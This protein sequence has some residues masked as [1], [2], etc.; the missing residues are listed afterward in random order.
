LEIVRLGLVQCSLGAIV[1]LCTSTF[2]RVMVVEL[3]LA[4]SVPAG[5]VAWH[6]A[7]QMSRPRWGFCAD[8]GARRTPWIIGGMGVLALGAVL[9]SD[10]IALM[11]RAP[12]VGALLAVVAF[13][14]I[15]IG[16]G[17]AGT[18]LLA[19][20]A[21]QTA[22]ERRPAAAAIT[23]I[24]MI[25]GIVVCTIIAG[26]QL[27][28]YSEQRLAMVTGGVALI[29]FLV[30]LAAVNGI[31][32]Q[33][34]TAPEDA[35]PSAPTSFRSAIAEVWAD[36]TARRFTI[37]VFVSM[38]AYSTQDL[39]LEPFAGLIFKLTP[40]QSTQLSGVQHMGVLAGMLLVGALGGALGKYA[41]G[42]RRAWL[43]G[44]T[45]AGC[46]ASALAL[47]GL[48]LAAIV[49]PA[50]PLKPT[51]FA[52]GFANGVFAVAAIGS[53]M[54]LAGAGG[55]GREGTRMGLWGAAQATAFGLGGFLGAVSVDALRAI[56]QADAPAFLVVFAIEAAAFGFAAALAA[57]VGRA[58]PAATGLPHAHPHT[59]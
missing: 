38:L 18:S 9:A 58:D 55:G 41:S 36:P 34:A 31:E 15:G 13:A 43:R 27:D 25:V 32:K 33:V 57:C 28:P 40:G 10:A 23:W 30:A 47:G 39:I 51:V 26:A 5:L 50:W 19:L 11:A 1:A 4:A 35:R 44:W 16:V 37:F 14:M 3:A 6:Y 45:I 24:L 8:Q 42:E 12:I 59:A 2:N 54:G 46:T 22:P 56:L 21:Q 53:M 29:A 17:A 20:M 49:G 7:V 52:L 48:A